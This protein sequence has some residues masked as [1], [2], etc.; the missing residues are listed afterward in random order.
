MFNRIKIMKKVFLIIL[1]IGIN[2][3]GHS[4]EENRMFGIGL[5]IARKRCVSKS[6]KDCAC[7][8]G[9]CTYKF[10]DGSYGDRFANVKLY[11]I[12]NNKIKL[13]FDNSIDNL[14]ENETIFNVDEIYEITGEALSNTGLS[15]IRILPNDYNYNV[16]ERNV[17]LD[18]EIE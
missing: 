6:G 2:L 15:K 11:I 10:K 16:S 14:R 1:F 9:L 5:D 13:E 8:F 7:G 4:Q 12:S 3:V 17:I 18:A